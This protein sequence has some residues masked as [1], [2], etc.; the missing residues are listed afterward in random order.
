MLA[1]RCC[2]NDY[3]SIFRGLFGDMLDF[4]G[5]VN[6]PLNDIIENEKEFV[7]E[8]SLAGVKKEN[9]SLSVDEGI[10][11]IKAERK[12]ENEGKYNRKETFYGKYEK[13]FSLPE[14]VNVEKINASFVDGILKLTIP[15]IEEDQ[16]ISKV[17]EIK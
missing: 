15:K 16:K 12:N 6:T 3:P 8:S 11:T 7:I 4:N 2:S 1:V 17:I 5:I 10:L 9:I 13:S 14:N